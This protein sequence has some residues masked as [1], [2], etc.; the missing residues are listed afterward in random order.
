MGS[1]IATKNKSR[2]S[3][4]QRSNCKY[5]VNILRME[6]SITNT[7]LKHQPQMCTVV[8]KKTHTVHTQTQTRTRWP[9][10]PPTTHTHTH[11]RAQKKTKECAHTNATHAQTHDRSDFI[12]PVLPPVLRTH[13]TRTSASADTHGRKRPQAREHGRWCGPAERVRAGGRCRRRATGGGHRTCR[14]SRE[15]RRL[16]AVPR[17]RSPAPQPHRLPPLHPITARAACHGERGEEREG[18][19]HRVKLEMEK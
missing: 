5:S 11:T 15:S 8:K 7:A 4:K 12:Q 9:R 19:S 1:R 14:Q 6:Q 13:A 18:E 16:P 10:P 2:F 3:N 17:L